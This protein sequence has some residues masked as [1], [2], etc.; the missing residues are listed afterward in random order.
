MPQPSRCGQITPLNRQSGH[1]IAFVAGQQPAMRLL[2]MLLLL[3]AITAPAFGDDLT[4][5]PPVSSVAIRAY[6]FGMVPFDGKFTRFHGVMHYDPHQ[7]GKCQV[8]LEIEAASLQMSS[9]TVTDRVTGAEFLD[10]AHYPAMAFSGA[11]QAGDVAGQLSLHGQSHPFTLDLE[12]DGSRMTATGRLTRAQWGM[13]ASPL[14]VGRTIRIRVELPMLPN[15][16]HA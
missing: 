4:L 16:E 3:L 5:Q 14:T 7:P 2:T 10:V 8:M 11:C 1:E 15:G 6:G 9:Q 12:R 13:T